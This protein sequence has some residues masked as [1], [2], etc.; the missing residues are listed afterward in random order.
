MLFAK[1]PPEDTIEWEQEE[2]SGMKMK[3]QRVITFLPARPLPYTD[4]DCQRQ[5]H[6][7]IEPLCRPIRVDLDYETQRDELLE[8][9]RAP[10]I[11][12]IILRYRIQK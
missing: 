7:A 11:Y 9:Y 5:L 6:A 4:I 8:Y 10:V 2:L 1:R 12:R 3:K